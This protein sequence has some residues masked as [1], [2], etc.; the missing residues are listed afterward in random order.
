MS[1][2][3]VI[4]MDSLF[5]KDIDYIKNLPNF[6]KVLEGS[7]VVKNIECIYPTVTYPCHT[8]I[9]TGVYP[10]KHGICHNEKF[11]PYEK[12]S[13]WYWYSEDIKHKTII[14]IA[15][16]N[17]LKTASVLWPVTGRGSADYNIA[18]IWTKNYGDDPYPIYC[19]SCSKE[20]MKTIYPKY[21]HIINW[22]KEPQL[23]EFGV[24][25][26]ED[27]IE[28]YAPDLM[29]IH[30]AYLDHTRHAF[31]IF[32]DEV[33]KALDRYDIW[34]RRLSESLK[35]AGIYDETNFIIL[36]DHGQIN[37]D[38]LVAPNVVF[39][40][41]GLLDID[42]ED[43]L[44]DYKAICHS[45]GIS[46]H[47][48]LKGSEY[49]DHVRSVLEE[50]KKDN[51]Y[52]I[53]EIFDRD[54]LK[55]MFNLECDAEFVLE[56]K[57]GTAFSNEYIGDKIRKTN[58]SDYK[59]SVATHGHMPSKGNKPPFIVSGPDIKK[60]VVIENARLVDEAPTIMKIF[61]I[62]LEDIDGKALDLIKK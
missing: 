5:T 44:K 39:R 33:Y 19:N 49:I 43:N 11:R 17:G 40:E 4:S 6:K 18:E 20:L 48:M 45:T 28:T 51:R 34:I 53:E 7:S 35:K 27:I 54:H 3:I 41:N 21:S 10:N 61:G 46:T 22:N 52:G 62:D 59:C 24:C 31:G 23:D 38:K 12:T 14:D 32:A 57:I 56:G 30:L 15:K 29:F 36:G 42:E 50:M 13:E 25:C 58:N 55:D 1:R 16:E 2:V 47:V 8:T 60:E 37:I 9:I 26:M